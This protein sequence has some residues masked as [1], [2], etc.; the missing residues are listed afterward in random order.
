LAASLEEEAL[1]DPVS[2]KYYVERA[3]TQDAMPAANIVAEAPLSAGRGG[4]T[5]SERLR[6]ASRVA[7]TRAK[8]AK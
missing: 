7:C 8:D 5:A 2:G 3:A 1:F 6:N 4:L